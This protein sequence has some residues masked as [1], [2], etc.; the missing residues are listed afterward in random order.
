[1]TKFS[2][3]PLLATNPGDATAERTWL[4]DKLVVVLVGV[5]DDPANF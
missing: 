1:M 4:I 2:P 5:A 3:L